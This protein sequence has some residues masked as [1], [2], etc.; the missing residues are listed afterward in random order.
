[1]H[2]GVTKIFYHGRAMPERKAY[3]TMRYSAIRHGNE[4]CCIESLGLDAEV[5]VH[6]RLKLNSQNLQLYLWSLNY[7]EV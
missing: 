6:G 1:L 4:K 2:C 3:E 5:S 7:N